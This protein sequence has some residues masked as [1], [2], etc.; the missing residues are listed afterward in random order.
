[1]SAGAGADRGTGALVVVFTP[2]AAAAGVLQRAV[3]QAGGLAVVVTTPDAL[4]PASE[5]AAAAVVDLDADGVLA[6]LN[7]LEAPSIGFLEPAS[8]QAVDAALAAG[9]VQV[10][11]R[12]T[13]FR[14][15]TEVLGPHLAR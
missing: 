3:E 9:C 1:M 13:C 12:S 2:D 5:G 10:L 11:P 15:L 6:V 4:V 14:V 8:A 7:S